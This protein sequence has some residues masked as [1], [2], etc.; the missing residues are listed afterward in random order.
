MPSRSPAAAVPAATPLAALPAVAVAAAAAA[1]LPALAPAPL[2]PTPAMVGSIFSVLLRRS[3]TDVGA[4][5]DPVQPLL[6]LRPPPPPRLPQ[7]PRAATPSQMMPSMFS[8]PM[9]HSCL[10]TDSDLAGPLLPPPALRAL[11]PPPSPFPPQASSVLVPSPSSSKRLRPQPCRAR[12]SSRMS[13]LSAYLYTYVST[14]LVT[15]QTDYYPG[16]HIF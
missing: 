8:V 4:T 16:L 6:L 1:L 3:Q 5:N 7:L 2:R 14:H 13:G 11:A 15:H 9:F 10:K 12:S